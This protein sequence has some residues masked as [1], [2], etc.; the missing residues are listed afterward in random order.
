VF[1]NLNQSYDGHSFNTSAKWN[2]LCQERRGPTAKGN[3]RAYH[4]KRQIRGMQREL[5]GKLFGCSIFTS[6][7]F[8]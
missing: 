6:E 4:I 7:L 3:I 5:R 8:L 2:D 1:L